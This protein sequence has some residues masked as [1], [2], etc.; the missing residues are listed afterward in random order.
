VSSLSPDE[1]ALLERADVKALPPAERR[2]YLL[3]N[4]RV[5]AFVVAFA[6][7]IRVL[8]LGGG[9]TAATILGIVDV[10][11]PETRDAAAIALVVI[12][13][14]L[15]PVTLWLG[16]RLLRKLAELRAPID[17]SELSELT[18]DD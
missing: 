7:G 10:A 4:R 2:A 5:G 18:R 1:R 6:G 17:E 9:A 16:A 14:A 3:Q 12:G 15:W 11:R 8:V 13:L